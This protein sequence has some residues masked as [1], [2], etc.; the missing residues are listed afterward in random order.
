VGYDD[1]EYIIE[2]RQVQR[3]LTVEGMIWAFTTTQVANWHPLTWLSHMLDCEIFGAWPGG[4]HLTNVIIHAANGVLLF[5]VLRRMTG[6]LWPSAFVAVVFVVHP[7]RAES[8][9]WVSERKDLLAGLFWMLTIGAYLRYLERP[10]SAGRYLMIVLALA[11]GLLAKPML[12]TLPFVL[13]LLDYWPLRRWRPAAIRPAAGPGERGNARGDSRRWQSA[14]HGSRSSGQLLIEKIPLFLLVAASC[15]ITFLV[16]RQGLAVQSLEELP[17]LS[18]LANA[19]VAYVSYIHKMLYPADLAVF[20]PLSTAGLPGWRVAGAV[21]LLGVISIWTI[22]QARRRPY[23]AVGWLWY[24]GTLVPVIGL[25]QVGDQALADRY[26]YLTQ[27]GLYIMVAWAIAELSAGWAF[28]R[29]A[30]GAGSAVVIAALMAGAWVQTSHWR[31]TVTLFS[32]TLTSTAET[33]LAQY[34]L[35]YGLDQ[36]GRTAQAVVHYRRALELN[37]RYADAHNNLG[38]ILD[39]Q[40][41][42]EQAIQHYQKAV[43]AN[44]R[45]GRAHYNW[46]N[47]LRKLGRTDEAIDHYRQA[48]GHHPEKPEFFDNLGSAL[49]A[50][51]EYEAARESFTKALELDPDRATTHFNLGA[52]LAK[53]GQDGRAKQRFQKSLEIK[54]GLAEAHVGLGD[55]LDRQGRPE[56]AI[57][58]YRRALEIDPQN[59]RSHCNWGVA[60]HKLGQVDQAVD[61][62]RQAA[63]LNPGDPTA[64][65]NL[66]DIF[67]EQGDHDQAA[68]HWQTA[69]SCAQAAGNADLAAKIRARLESSPPDESGKPN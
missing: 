36:Q 54:P 39:R 8:V 34:T 20:Y 67:A 44:P 40:G 46:G 7:L 38:D 24:V 61:H 45:Y 16:Q 56:Q 6:A 42:T 53:L 41:K 9:A 64:H 47:A 51:G 15:V 26:T 25:V 69:L 60:L 11:L 58:H 50:K 68:E 57:E 2:N 62:C 35:G 30:L 33:D 23:L 22:T 27:I 43:E 18:R 32:H 31:N 17:F 5:L 4:H 65:L 29:V 59:D 49:I 19:L 66:G 12:V 28:R 10:S 3:G 21:L 13:L 63:R 48:I 37:P 52:V 14:E 55:I 1:G